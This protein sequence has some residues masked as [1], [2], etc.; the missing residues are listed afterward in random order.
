M[1]ALRVGVAALAAGSVMAVGA[2][3]RADDGPAGVPVVRL[4]M[5]PTIHFAP[6]DRTGVNF[7]LDVVIGGLG[8]SEGFEIDRVGLLFGGDLGYSLDTH[9]LHAFTIAPAIGIGNI[10]YG[11]AYH[12]RLVAGATYEKDTAIGMRNSLVGHFF[13]DTFTL[14]VGH[15]FTHYRDQL[16]HDIH[17]LL[18]VNPAGVI[19]LL[20]Q[21]VAALR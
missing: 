8:F 4:A 10:F 1:R 16:N 3:A 15:Q 12:P 11:V 19:F 13:A 9:G 7:G 14:D 20:S 17:I 5:G 21:A 6:Q 18:G 2:V